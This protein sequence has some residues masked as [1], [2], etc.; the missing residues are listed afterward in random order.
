[1]RLSSLEH[2][3]PSFFHTE[4][5][6]SAMVRDVLIFVWFMRT[7]AMKAQT[8]NNEQNDWMKCTNNNNAVKMHGTNI[9]TI[10]Q[11]VWL[12][13]RETGITKS[14]VPVVV[15]VVTELNFVLIH[16]NFEYVYTHTRRNNFHDEQK[17]ETKKTWCRRQ[18]QRRRRKMHCE[19]NAKNK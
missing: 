19:N 16:M 17:R 13:A 7:T 12:R 5:F 3:F 6:G 2:F 8:E 11:S 18:R 4:K 1:M 14:F 10:S 9:E 15:E